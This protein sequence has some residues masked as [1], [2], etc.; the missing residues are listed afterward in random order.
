MTAMKEIL[1]VVTNSSRTK[2]FRGGENHKIQ[3]IRVIHNPRVRPRM[4]TPRTTQPPNMH[5]S[6]I[7]NSIIVNNKYG[8]EKEYIRRYSLRVCH[9]I[10]REINK[11]GL[12]NIILVATPVMT[13]IL[14]S[15]LNKRFLDK[16]VYTLKKDMVNNNLVDVVT[17]LS[18]QFQKHFR[19][20]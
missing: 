9:A 2:L 1:L 16:I 15:K 4:I 14:R 19:L 17:S 8:H 3:E 10:A 11:S 20:D 6:D 13:N 5:A 18:F 12:Q 7:A